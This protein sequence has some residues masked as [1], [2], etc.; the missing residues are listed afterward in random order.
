M[1]VGNTAR[2]EMQSRLEVIERDIVDAE[3]DAK[4]H[5]ALAAQRKED[6]ERGRAVADQYKVVIDRLRRNAALTDPSASRA[7][8]I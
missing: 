1:F 7:R 2:E 3:R 4:H 6:V 8:V 5:E